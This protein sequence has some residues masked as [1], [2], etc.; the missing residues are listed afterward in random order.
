MH[1]P[2]TWLRLL[3]QQPKTQ[4][5]SIFLADTQL[6]RT[7]VPFSPRHRTTKAALVKATKYKANPVTGE[8][9]VE[10]RNH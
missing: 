3:R 5:F 7:T 2:L 1:T 8:V 9:R 4:E 10:N 6:D